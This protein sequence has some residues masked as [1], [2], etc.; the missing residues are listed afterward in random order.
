MNIDCDSHFTPIE[1]FDDPEVRK[2]FT[3]HMNGYRPRNL[4]GYKLDVDNDESK[5]F[6]YYTDHHGHRGGFDATNFDIPLRIEAMKEAGYDKQCV[7]TQTPRLCLPPRAEAAYART[8]NDAM[9]KICEKYEELISIGDIPH[10]DPGMAIEEME[11]CVKDLGFPG[12]NMEGS[13]FAAYDGVQSME[14]TDW[15]E[16]YRAAD[17]LRTTIFCHGRGG[18]KTFLYADPGLPAYERRK[19]FP[20]R[21]GQGVYGFVLQGEIGM[22]GMIFS[23]LLDKYTN[24][25]F[26]FLEA[27]AGW[28]PGL[29]SALDGMYDAYRIYVENG[30]Y[31][32]YV[33]S[34]VAAPVG[35][36][37]KPSEYVRDHF[38]FSLTYNGPL[39]MKTMLPV[40]VNKAGLQ[41][42]IV[43]ESDWPHVEG[44]L[45]LP[46]L[47]SECP[48]LI[49]DA[50][51]DIL[52]RNAEKALK[53]KHAP[54]TY[55]KLYAGK[56][57]MA[58]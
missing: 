22:A 47:V 41:H 38:L 16:F 56:K 7:I 58:S 45:D 54:S 43:V 36:R 49:E 4:R 25:K 44:T 15:W 32:P 24:L 21:G 5:K 46:R 19:F 57:P 28:L 23:G 39:Q 30:A 13:W 35:L 53:L 33:T 2:Y 50:K 20:G 8:R 17:R 3:F 1:V 18:G 26:I 42:N 31:S 34:Q 27:D 11:R 37:K 51:L 40:M 29:M 9:V 6:P 52:G 55:A 48:D 14:A 10:K 12:V